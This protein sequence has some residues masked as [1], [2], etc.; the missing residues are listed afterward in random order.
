MIKYNNLLDDWLGKAMVNQLCLS[1]ASRGNQ[2]HVILIGQHLCD[3]L[4][5]FHTVAEVFRTGVTICYKGFFI[6]IFI[7]YY[8]FNVCNSFAKIMQTNA[9]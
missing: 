7:P 5:F 2:S 6:T 1:D 9:M 4:G 3:V 8:I